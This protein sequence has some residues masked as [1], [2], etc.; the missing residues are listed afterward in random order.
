M[1]IVHIISKHMHVEVAPVFAA[2]VAACRHLIGACQP[3][4]WVV[5]L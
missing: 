5:R 2:V 1:P 3:S 4:L